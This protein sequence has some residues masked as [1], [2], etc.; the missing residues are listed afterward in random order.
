[1]LGVLRNFDE[2]I[3]T[4]SK[5]TLYCG[6][7]PVLNAPVKNYSQVEEA[8]YFKG[9]LAVYEKAGAIVFRYRQNKKGAM[10]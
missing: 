3:L 6:R 5:V 10:H 7:K 2:A 4:N 9:P 1:M 8:L